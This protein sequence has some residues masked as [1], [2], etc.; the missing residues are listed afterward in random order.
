LLAIIAAA[1]ISSTP[2]L[3]QSG[4]LHNF[5]QGTDGLSPSASLILDS[6]GN[7][8]GATYSG[9]TYNS[10]IVFE[11][12]PGAAGTWDETVIH[13][14]GSGIDGRNPQASLIFDAAGN[15]YG[16]T[17]AGGPLHYGTVFQLTPVA[18]G[19]WTETVIH[20]FNSRDGQ[21]PQS[22][23]ILDLAGNLYGTSFVGGAYGLGVAFELMPKGGGVW[24]EKVLH[25]FGHGQDGSYCE[26]GL[27][28]DRAGN[29]YGT[30]VNGGTYNEG[31]VFEL[32]STGGV[33]SETILHN[34]SSNSTDGYQPYA[35]LIFDAVGNLYGTTF[36]GGT[37][38]YGTVFEL[39]PS[40]GGNWT[41]KALHSFNGTATG[42]AF[43]EGGLIFDDLGN[44]YGTTVGGG[45][46]GFGMVFKLAP[47][48]GG[49]WSMKVLH[50]FN[51]K[52]GY[53]PRTG[54]AIDAF[55][56]LFATTTSGGAYKQ[57]TVFEIKR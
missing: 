48:A 38:G 36:A 21:A 2:A 17:N 35:G 3:T 31:T 51:G 34:F 13:H 54:L 26:A 19:G 45:P 25:S 10:G 30:T 8:Y 4:V 5:G 44:L 11:L 47:N 57:G 1:L 50:S 42:G 29:L 22:S 41:E 23:L 7:L 27:I 14:F 40:A 20:N 46:S 37:R 53:L 32:T 43:A 33:W 15:L 39:M 12:T 6:A 24:T 49:N 9:G 18:G 55:G 52:D 16:T 28:L 56:N